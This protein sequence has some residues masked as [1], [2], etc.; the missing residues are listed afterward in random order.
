ME[1]LR[2]WNKTNFY[3]CLSFP[4]LH[5]LLLYKF[6]TKNIKKKRKFLIIIIIN[7]LK[8]IEAQW[9]ENFLLNKNLAVLV[10]KITLNSLNNK[11]KKKKIT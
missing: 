10:I 7:N 6:Y 5:N 9:T 1:S 4:F 3:D 8:R 2:P 11:K